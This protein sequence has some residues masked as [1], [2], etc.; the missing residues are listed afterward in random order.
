[1]HLKAKSA[2][3][4]EDKVHAPYEVFSRFERKCTI[5]DVE[6]LE[7]FVGGKC[8]CC[9]HCWCVAAYFSLNHV[10]GA[11]SHN[12]EDG[13]ALFAPYDFQC[14]SESCHKEEEEDGGH[15]IP[16]AHSNCLRY[17]NFLSFNF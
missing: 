11:C 3:V 15:V 6:A 4:V 10:V 5:V 8:F 9:K 17:F 16:L 14:F 13:D 1:M 7:D 2:E 12:F